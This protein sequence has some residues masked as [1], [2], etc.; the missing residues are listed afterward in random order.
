ML[1]DD[2]LA[3]LV[4]K[5]VYLRVLVVKVLV[6]LLPCIL[7]LADCVLIRLVFGFEDDV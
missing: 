2:G 4:S 3:S 6:Y 1:L 5:L 7:K